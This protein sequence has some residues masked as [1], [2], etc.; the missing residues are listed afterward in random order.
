MKS[1]QL[2]LSVFESK[3]SE[4]GAYKLEVLQKTCNMLLRNSI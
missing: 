3:V 1:S 4:L 2:L